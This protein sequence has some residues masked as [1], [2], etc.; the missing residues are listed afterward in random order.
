MKNLLLL[1]F[2]LFTA[3]I[4]AQSSTSFDERLLELFSQEELETIQ[5]NEPYRLELIEYCLDN[6]YYFVEAPKEKDYSTRLSGTVQ[7]NDVKNF[8]FFKL[9]IQLKE[10]DYQ[11]FK[12]K[13]KDLLL[14]VKSGQHVSSEMN[15]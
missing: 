5:K 10:N 3:S 2:F 8:N 1:T 11:Y 13:D 15:K 6:A 4:S 12:V 14:V 7:I 9:E